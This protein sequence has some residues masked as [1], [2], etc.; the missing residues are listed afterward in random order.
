MQF[1]QVVEI[2]DIVVYLTLVS[3]LIWVITCV[4][5]HRLFKKSAAQ[6]KVVVTN[7]D[8]ANGDCFNNEFMRLK[9]IHSKYSPIS[10]HNIQ[11]KKR[12]NMRQKPKQ[13][14]KSMIIKL[15]K[16]TQ[17]VKNKKRTFSFSTALTSTFPDWFISMTENL[18]TK[19][20]TINNI[21]HPSL[22]IS[23]PENKHLIRWR[24]F[25]KSISE[26]TSKKFN[27]CCGRKN[28]KLSKDIDDNPNFIRTFL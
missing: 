2:S 19:D 8:K 27:C 20:S 21:I 25:C 17:P 12:A 15:S 10:E 28:Q 22:G 23:R 11:N 3:V 7:G 13:L 5:V 4:Y 18:I 26:S 9:A 16:S 6:A 14:F 1:T 24:L